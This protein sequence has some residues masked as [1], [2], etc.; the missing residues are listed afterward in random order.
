MGSVRASEATTVCFQG[1]GMVALATPVWVPN[2]IVLGQ[3][4]GTAGAGLAQLQVSSHIPLARWGKGHSQCHH[5][6]LRTL[7]EVT[8]LPGGPSPLS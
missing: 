8:S 4:S 6:G 5:C 2:S 3:D 7:Q 1:M